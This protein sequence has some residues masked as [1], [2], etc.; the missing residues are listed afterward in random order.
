MVREIVFKP[1]DNPTADAIWQSDGKEYGT[2]SLTAFC[3]K[4][5][6]EQVAKS[7]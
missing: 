4:L 1:L 3:T 7:V 5:L 6:D 2:A